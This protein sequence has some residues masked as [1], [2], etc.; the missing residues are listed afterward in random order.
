MSP[1]RYRPDYPTPSEASRVTTER[2]A[3]FT[4]ATAAIAWLVVFL[5][6]CTFVVPHFGGW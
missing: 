2:R 4:E 3:L 1:R 5:I 6:F